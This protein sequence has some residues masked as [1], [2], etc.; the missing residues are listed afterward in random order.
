MTASLVDDGAIARTS[1]GY[2]TVGVVLESH[3]SHRES[4]ESPQ[5]PAPG[6]SALRESSESSRTSKG[7]KGTPLPLSV[8]T[9]SLVTL[10]T[11]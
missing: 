5:S 2:V 3:P 6:D 11:P 10:M 4:S 8:P 7:S 1:R 9:I